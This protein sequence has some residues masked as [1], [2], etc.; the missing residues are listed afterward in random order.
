MASEAEPPRVAPRAQTGPEGE[1]PEDAISFQLTREQEILTV[2]IV[3]GQEETILQ[4]MY[5]KL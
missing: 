1:I 2:N 4:L 5:A 3:L